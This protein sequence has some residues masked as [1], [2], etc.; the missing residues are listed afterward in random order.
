MMF[1]EGKER[2]IIGIGICII[3]QICKSFFF[4]VLL[5]DVN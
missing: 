3:K 2:L 4:E 1:V 5:T